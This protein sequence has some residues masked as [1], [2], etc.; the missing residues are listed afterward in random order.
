M[1][2]NAGLHL[3]SCTNVYR[4]ETWAETF[5]SLKNHTLRVRERVCPR[6]PFAIGL[7]L[8][9]RA[10]HDL[11]QPAVLLEFQ[12]WLGRQGCY[13][14]AID[15]FAFGR[16]RGAVLKEQVYE[17]DWRSPERLAYT[18]L[19]FELLAQLEPPDVEGS[20]STLPCSFK[21]FHLHPDELKLVRAN[22]WH[23]VEHVARVCEQT[24]RRLLLSLDPEPLCVL[25]S[26]GEVLQL[27]DRM[28]SEHPRDPRLATYLGVDY[29]TCHFA[30]EFE[31][32]LN[33]I[34]CIAEHGIR[35]GKILV[36]A[37]LKVRPTP[38]A[39]HALAA[40]TH[41]PCLHQVVVGR[42]DGQRCIYADLREALITE[43]QEPEYAIADNPQLPEWRV[44]LHVPLHCPPLPWFDTTADH[45][46]GTLDLLAA[47]PGL[48]R[49]L[50]LD[51]C[52]WEIL[53]PALQDRDRV[54][55]WVDEYDWTMTRLS[56]RGM[57]RARAA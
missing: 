48:C 9:N 22:L 30:V 15:G 55:Q 18:N 4:D 52:A 11:R 14:P 53:P 57:A 35:F 28:R 34:P 42:P 32:P 33:A 44:H 27:F 10:A 50:Q 17:P 39:L 2:L 20:V 38:E 12:R 41:D 51:P 5:E 1:K 7:R 46:L 54:D 8:S 16:F 31:E 23:C 24:G 29:D 56:E 26:S 49:Q 40:F 25:E 43:P 13:V 3:A 21:G 45:I 47:N 6:Q 36:S 37:G 19:L